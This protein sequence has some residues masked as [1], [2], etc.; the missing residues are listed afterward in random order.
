MNNKKTHKFRLINSIQHYNKQ[1]ILK[2]KMTDLKNNFQLPNKNYLIIRRIYK[3]ASLKFFPLKVLKKYL[4]VHS[5]VT[6]AA[7]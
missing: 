7:K 4:H 1:L 6:L 2:K 5:F 3:I